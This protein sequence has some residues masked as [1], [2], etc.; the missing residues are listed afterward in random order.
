MVVVLPRRARMVFYFA[1]S[2]AAAAEDSG[3]G[4]TGAAVDALGAQVAAADPFGGPTAAGGGWK[5]SKKKKGG[6][7]GG[8]GGND[9]PAP[10]PAPDG[11]KQRAADPADAGERVDPEHPLLFMGRD[12]HEKY[13][14]ALAAGG[15]ASGEGEC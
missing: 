6:G 9:T 15:P 10:A 8:G 12:K 3:A 11:A 13:G 14:C 1:L 2:P 4:S 7:G 5:G